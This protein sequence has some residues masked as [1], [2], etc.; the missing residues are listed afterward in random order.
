[1]TK[2]EAYELLNNKKVYVNGKSLDIQD[3][4]FSLGFKWSVGD[5]K[6]RCVDSPFLFIHC[7]K[8][9]SHSNNMIFFKNHQYK[10]I[11]DEDILNIEIDNFKFKTGDILA[12]K[13]SDTLLIYAGCKNKLIRYYCF[14]GEYYQEIF[15]KPTTGAGYIEEYRFASVFEIDKMNKFLESN[16]KRW[17]N[18]LKC[19]EDIKVTFKPFDKVLCRNLITNNWIPNLFSDLSNLSKKYPYLM[20][21]GNRYKQCIPY[22]GNEHLAFTINFP[23]IIEN[24]KR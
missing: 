4:L 2:E 17:N 21:D 13:R 18:E 23:V 24:K 11:S 15:D 10:E 1:M 9:F 7:D 19:L 20:I 14:F 8:R 16:S 6:S 5:T 22:E 3:K 12:H